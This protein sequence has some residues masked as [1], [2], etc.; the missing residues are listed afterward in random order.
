MGE[1]VLSIHCCSCRPDSFSRR[2]C[3]GYHA[4]NLLGCKN[5]FVSDTGVPRETL[6]D[7]K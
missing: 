3:E 7:E 2:I 5:G 1:G 4:L 6:G